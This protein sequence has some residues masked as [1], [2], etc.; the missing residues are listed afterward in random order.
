LLSVGKI[1][2]RK[3]YQSLTVQ[4]YGLKQYKGLGGTATGSGAGTAVTMHLILTHVGTS[5]IVGK[6]HR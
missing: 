3:R 4:A 2:Y 5:E 1:A 6:E